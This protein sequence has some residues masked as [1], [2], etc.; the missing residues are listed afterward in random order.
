[1]IQ[2]RIDLIKKQEFEILNIKSQHLR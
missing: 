1:M 2:Q